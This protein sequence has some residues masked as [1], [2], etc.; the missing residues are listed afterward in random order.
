MLTASGVNRTFGLGD[1]AGGGEGLVDLAVEL[2]AVGDDEE[3]PGA[4]EFAQDF[5]GEEDH[6]EALAAALGVPEDAEAALFLADGADGLDSVV[7]A[8]ILVVLGEDLDER[9][10]TLAIEDEVFDEIEQAGVVADAA[11]DGI[12]R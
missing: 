12:E 2:L 5:L 6:R 9:A 3:G 8:E 10:T 7:D 4:G 11:Q 1:G